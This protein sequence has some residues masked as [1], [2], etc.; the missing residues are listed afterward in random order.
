MCPLH[1]VFIA[2]RVRVGSVKLTSRLLRFDLISGRR[3][4]ST[5]AQGYRARY[6]RDHTPEISVFR[7]SVSRTNEARLKGRHVREE[8]I[9]SEI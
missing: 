4:E 2:A 9:R 6:A 8:F 7:E 3:A 5:R 1:N